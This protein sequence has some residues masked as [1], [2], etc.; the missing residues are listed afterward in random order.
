MTREQRKE[1]SPESNLSEQHADSPKRKLTQVFF[2]LVDQG[3]VS[4]NNFVTF[5][6]VSK[7]CSRDDLN[8]YVLAWSIFN[9]FRVI[10]E[11]GLAA[12]YFVFAHDKDQQRDSFLGSSLIHQ[13][14]FAVAVSV[15]FVGLASMFGWRGSPS[16]MAT[17]ILS[18]VIASP[19]ILLRDHLRAI[20]CAHFRYGFAV[21][22][23]ACAMAIQ[24]AII[25]TAHWQNRL[26]VSVVFFAMGLSSLIPALLWYMLRPVPIRFDVSRFRPDWSTTY[27]YSKW[28][29]AARIFPSVAMGVMPWIVMW[30]VDENAAGTLGGCITL[31]NISN[32]FVFGANYFFLPRAVK[33]LKDRGQTAM[34]KV[35][36]ETA[37][38]F[39]IVLT[40]LCLGYLFLGNWL[41]VQLFDQSFEGYAILA[42]LI[43]LSYLIVSYS[44][45][46][47]NGMTALG[48]PEGLFWGE[49]AFGIV[50]ILLGTL[51]TIQFGLIGTAVALCIAS[52]F[53]TVVESWYLRRLLNQD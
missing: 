23:S 42:S 53:A 41:L 29:V 37:I 2:A 25:L 35:L 3:F 38:V 31:A 17:C 45:I 32:M 43:G 27:A 40:S 21:M 14:L 9:I 26:N 12:P 13:A 8:L 39:S 44:T 15:L 4:L 24:I 33:A 28:L 18:L 36:W 30:A 16:G 22:L 49:L 51:L 6:L 1:P 20:S 52:L 47:G 11:R 5:I 50:A 10:Q 7:F 46:A 48:N 34:C 19:F